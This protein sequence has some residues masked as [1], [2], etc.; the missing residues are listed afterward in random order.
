[1]SVAQLSDESFNCANVEGFTPLHYAAG[2][3]NLNIT[4]YLVEACGCDPEFPDNLGLTPGFCSVLQ[5]RKEVSE[6]L[7]QVWS[8]ISAFYVHCACEESFVR[9]NSHHMAP[10]PARLS[11]ANAVRICM[12]V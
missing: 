5:G 8:L 9:A 3:G 2:E 7:L 10:N 12:Y 4:K 6:Y 1:M 11:S